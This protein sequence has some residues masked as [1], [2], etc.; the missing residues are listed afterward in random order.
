M[1]GALILGEAAVSANLVS[2]ILIIIVAIT[3]MCSFAIP[4]FSINFTLR[5]YRFVYIIL[6]YIAGFLGIALGLFVQLC[7]LCSLKSF[8]APYIT[9]VDLHNNTRSIIAYFIRPIWK[10]EKKAY[11]INSKKTYS[12]DRISMEW[13]KSKGGN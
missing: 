10:R 3:G 9:N 11:F 6:A 5:I 7:I 2:P 12:Q 13:K 1:F 8:G 4:D